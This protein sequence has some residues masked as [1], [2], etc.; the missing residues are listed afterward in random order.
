M[1]KDIKSS[2]SRY[3]IQE[4]YN[5]LNKEQVVDFT[6]DFAIKPS[7]EPSVEKTINIE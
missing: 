5:N 2:I 6:K 7:V 3:L 4:S 1:Y